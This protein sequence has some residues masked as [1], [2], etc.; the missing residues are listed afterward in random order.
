MEDIV[1][2]GQLIDFSK[3]EDFPQDIKALTKTEKREILMREIYDFYKSEYDKRRVENWKRYIQWLK[4]NRT[5]DT[6]ENQ[7]RFKRNKL[8]IREIGFESLCFLLKHIP[9]DDL[10]YFISTGK[11]FSHTGRNF[12]SWISQWFEKVIHISKT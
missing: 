6:K 3:F 1:S 8:Y 10:H 11:E 2:I 9:L 7:R 4:A 5:P 12:S